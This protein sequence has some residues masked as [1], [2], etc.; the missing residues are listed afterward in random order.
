MLIRETIDR[1]G[2]AILAKFETLSR[3]NMCVGDDSAK[4]FDIFSHLTRSPA[5]TP[6]A[7]LPTTLSA[8]DDQ[9]PSRSCLVLVCL[10]E[11]LQLRL[12]QI[13]TGWVYDVVIQ[14][15]NASM[16]PNRN[17]NIHDAQAEM[18]LVFGDFRGTIVGTKMHVHPYE[19]ELVHGER[20]IRMAELKG[21]RYSGP[22]YFRERT[23]RMAELK[24]HRYSGPT[25]F[26]ERTIRM[27]ELK[28]HRYS[29]PTYFRERTIR[30]AELKRH[31]YSGPTQ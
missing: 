13:P 3:S 18:F 31:R 19:H 10:A 4:P 27:A 16:N 6:S 23:I 11:A 9:S 29:G 17:D 20:T 1:F 2:F 14:E 22:T 30:M 5:G 7:P 28:R 15:G 26:R 8:E 12:R 24:R 25:Y 21:H